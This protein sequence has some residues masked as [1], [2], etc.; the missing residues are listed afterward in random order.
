MN[1]LEIFLIENISA[2]TGYFTSISALRR[3][4]QEKTTISSDELK[5]V[6]FYA[7]AKQCRLVSMGNVV[8]ILKKCASKLEANEKVF[9]FSPK[10]ASIQNIIGLQL[11]NVLSEKSVSFEIEGQ[12]GRSLPRLMTVDMLDLYLD[13]LP[14]FPVTILTAYSSYSAVL[15]AE[16][17]GHLVITGEIVPPPYLR[18]VPAWVWP[19]IPAEMK[20]SHPLVFD[21][22]PLIQ[23]SVLAVFNVIAPDHGSEEKFK[24]IN[25]ELM[26]SGA[27]MKER[28]RNTMLSEKYSLET[29]LR[30]LR[31]PDTK[32]EIGDSASIEVLG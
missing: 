11:Y 21:Y 17:K 29:Q 24:V 10:L 14:A 8:T 18:D 22:R 2:I 9:F 19:V 30:H 32:M 1:K 25:S 5:S 13:S 12:T 7:V 26:E 31:D 16:G 27:D 20:S 4:L 23:S 6:F 15:A 3:I 28:V